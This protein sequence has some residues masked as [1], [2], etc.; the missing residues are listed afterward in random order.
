M[1]KKREEEE[2][3]EFEEFQISKIKDTS[4]PKRTKQSKQASPGQQEESDK[5]GAAAAATG[6]A[7]TGRSGARGRNDQ[8]VVSMK[9]RFGNDRREKEA[10]RDAGEKLKKAKVEQYFGDLTREIYLSRPEIFEPYVCWTSNL[11]GGV[12]ANTSGLGVASET[13]GEYLK[14]SMGKDVKFAAHKLMLCL[15]MDTLY[16]DFGV[17]E[18]VD[19]SHLCH[20]RSCWRPDHLHAES[21]ADNMARSSGHGCGGMLVDLTE[22]RFKDEC[23]HSVKC[24]VVRS[25]SSPWTPL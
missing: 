7:P 21:H 16:T 23:K 6:V 2:E 18:K 5:A 20:N 22:R 24:K 4:E 19:A 25:F 8:A 10:M 15:K 12:S 3:E 1:S 13:C 11:G 14:V 17:K 9:E